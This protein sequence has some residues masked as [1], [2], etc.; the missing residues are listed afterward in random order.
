MVAKSGFFFYVQ[1]CSHKIYTLLPNLPLIIK[2]VLPGKNKRSC[3]KIC[4]D[5]YELFLHLT[6]WYFERQ[7][8]KF[9]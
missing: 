4:K 6:E 7:L 3:P 8:R 9:K 5:I 1:H 2:T